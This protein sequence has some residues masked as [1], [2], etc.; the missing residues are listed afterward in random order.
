[1][2]PFMCTPS[3]HVLTIWSSNVKHGKSLSAQLTMYLFGRKMNS[4]AIMTH[5]DLE[6]FRASGDI[7]GTHGFVEAR[8]GRDTR[9]HFP[10]ARKR[11]RL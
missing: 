10:P 6:D 3:H 5:P 11:G 7:R 4:N 2:C 8:Y 9:S 1:M